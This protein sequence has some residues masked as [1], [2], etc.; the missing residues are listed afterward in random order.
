M[1]EKGVAEAKII[2][3]LIGKLHAGNLRRKLTIIDSY[4]LS[5]G[6]L[7]HLKKN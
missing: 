1:F 3:F 2:D 5:G 6:G 7:G 4:F